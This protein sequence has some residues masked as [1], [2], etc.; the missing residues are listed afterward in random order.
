LNGVSYAQLNLSGGRGGPLPSLP[1]SSLKHPKESGTI[2]ATIDKS[3]Q[4]GQ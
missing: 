1:M 2:Y 3:A 4:E